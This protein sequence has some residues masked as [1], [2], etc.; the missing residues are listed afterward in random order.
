MPFEP[1]GTADLPDMLVARLARLQG[2]V[3]LARGD[4]ELALRR[5]DEAERGWRRRLAPAASGDLFAA[6][7]VDLGRPPVAGL[8]EP[9]VELARTLADRAD[10]LTA[11]GRA[12]EAASAAAEAARLAE[13][14]RFDGDWARRAEAPAMGR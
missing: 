12:T 13:A 9:G 14:L 10:A 6:T 1:V 3:A 2:R 8:V 7:L 5:L 4:A 11:L